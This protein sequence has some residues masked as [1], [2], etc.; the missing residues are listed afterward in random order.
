MRGER[1][2]LGTLSCDTRGDGQYVSGKRA[3]S[4]P[5]GNGG[6]AA[7]A[8]TQLTTRLSERALYAPVHYTQG[9]PRAYTH[10]RCT[11]CRLNGH[12]HP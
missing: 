4:L 11:Y 10:A 8:E 7:S 9:T 6:V 1:R 12:T 2:D 3:H 5:L